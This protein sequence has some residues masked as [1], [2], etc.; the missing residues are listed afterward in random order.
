MDGA[1]EIDDAELQKQLDEVNQEADRIAA[2]KKKLEL[3]QQIR[4]QKE[5]NQ[6]SKQQINREAAVIDYSN[7]HKILYKVGNAI[8]STAQKASNATVAY[9]LGS[10]D[11]KGISEAKVPQVGETRT[12]NITDYILLKNFAAKTGAVNKTPEGNDLLRASNPNGKSF[13][14]SAGKGGAINTRVTR[15][16]KEQYNALMT[17]KNLAVG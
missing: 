17:G 14:F 13:Y 3:M 8:A 9:A 5:A 11:L 1:D 4:A 16:S 10:S 7:K 12:I 6:Q 2:N 15:L